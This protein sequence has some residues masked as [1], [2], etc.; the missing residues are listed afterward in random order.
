MAAPALGG[1]GSG[2]GLGLRLLESLNSVGGLSSLRPG[3]QVSW[4]PYLTALPI[5]GIRGGQRGAGLTSKDAFVPSGLPNWLA[6]LPAGCQGGVTAVGGPPPGL[7]PPLSSQGRQ[8]WACPRPSDAQGPAEKHTGS[9]FPRPWLWPLPSGCGL[10]QGPGPRLPAC[11]PESL[12]GC[13]PLTP[14]LLA[15]QAGNACL[16]PCLFLAPSP[17]IMCTVA[18][19]GKPSFFFLL[20][21]SRSFHPSLPS[22]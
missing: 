2:G 5:C 19:P 9:P 4:S 11:W 1:G 6:S 3:G 7:D 15:S 13:S 22:H 14:G 21:L 18:P 16:C 8:G 12:Y 10:G 17:L 20:L